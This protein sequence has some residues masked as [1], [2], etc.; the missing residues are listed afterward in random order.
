M[1]YFSK[2]STLQ[3][4]VDHIYGR[5]NVL[6]D[7]YRPHMFVKEFHMY[8]DYLKKK[9]EET[10]EDLTA[11]QKKYLVSFIQNLEKGNEYY[12][13]LFTD[14]KGYFDEAKSSIKKELEATKKVLKQLNTEIENLSVATPVSQ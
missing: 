3:E 1:A 2:K 9:I 4:M 13:S 6:N 8:I 14:V 10:K 5:I 7:T 11:K 12:D